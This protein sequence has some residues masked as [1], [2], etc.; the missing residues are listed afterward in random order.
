MKIK[1]IIKIL[2]LTLTAVI[3]LF[4]AVSCGD[5]EPSHSFDLTKDREGNA[6]SLPETIEK[7]ISIGPSNTEVLAALGFADKIIAA[8]AWS[9]NVPGITAAV[10]SLPSMAEIDNEFIIDLQPDIIIVTGMSKAGGNNPLQVVENTGICVIII[11]SSTTIEGIKEDIRYIAAVLGA[12]SK[13]EEIVTAMEKDIAD[14]KA[15]GDTV[16][17]KKT[18]Y[19]EVS[20]APWMYSFGSGT[21]LNE[22][23]ELVGAV[24]I[25]ASEESWLSVADEQILNADPDVILTSVNYL[26]DAIGEIKSRDGWGAVTAVQNE[27]VYYIDTDSSNRPSHNIVKA[28]KEMASAVYPDKFN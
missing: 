2:A 3:L 12:V 8:D 27:A 23:I 7:I 11:P 10:A 20:A 6:I 25:L 22:M 1:P 19:F 15:V 5:S 24:N 9:E 16:T 17:E 14:I 4:A 26:D 13:G 21:F 18:V 28:L